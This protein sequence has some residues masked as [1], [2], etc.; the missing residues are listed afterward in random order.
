MYDGA[1]LVFLNLHQSPNP[2][3]HE[4]A[5][6]LTTSI[7]SEQAYSLYLLHF[8]PQLQLQVPLPPSHAL[9]SFCILKSLLEPNHNDSLKSIFF[10]SFIEV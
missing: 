2:C 5:Y 1:D 3:H 9:S 10:S 7:Q 8:Y 6:S 4:Q